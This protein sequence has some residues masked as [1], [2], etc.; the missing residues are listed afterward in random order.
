MPQERGAAAEGQAQS[1]AVAAV[2]HQGDQQKG[3]QAGQDL[4]C[5]QV[6][7]LGPHHH[8]PDPDRNP[9]EII[10]GQEAQD[11]GPMVQ[12]DSHGVPQPQQA[13]EETEDRE[14]AAK[15]PAVSTT[16]L[17]GQGLS[18]A[19]GGSNSNKHTKRKK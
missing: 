16:Q 14:A 5:P 9:Q 12:E 1:G 11:P 4:C 2:L 10:Q 19:S 13:R 8:Q 6:H 17:H 15:K 3:V 18:L 7:R